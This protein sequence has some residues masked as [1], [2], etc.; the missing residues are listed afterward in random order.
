[1]AHDRDPRTFD[2]DA[3]PYRRVCVVAPEGSPARE[4]VSFFRRSMP[5]L[6]AARK[7]Y[8]CAPPY[9]RTQATIVPPEEDRAS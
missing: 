8:V 7:R 9:D 2:L 6:V 1:M 3:A 4:W 5:G